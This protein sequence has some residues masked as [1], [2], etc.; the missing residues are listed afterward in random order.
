MA[1]FEYKV[2]YVLENISYRHS[3]GLCRTERMCDTGQVHRHRVLIER[4]PGQQI[5]DRKYDLARTFGQGSRVEAS[6]MNESIIV[7]AQNRI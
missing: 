7:L 3:N 6:W 5:K 1:N 4:M 2:V